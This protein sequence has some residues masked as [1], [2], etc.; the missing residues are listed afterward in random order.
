VYVDALGN[1][2]TYAEFLTRT[3]PG[4]SF[5]VTS[6]A[7]S[8]FKIVGAASVAAKVTRDACIEGWVFEEG[9]EGGWS[10]DLG[11]GYPS[12]PKTQAWIKNSIDP[13]FG[14]PALARFSWTTVKVALERDAHA[15]KWVD[16]GQEALVSAFQSA[17]GRDK[18]RCA[19]TKDL[20]IKSIGTL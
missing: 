2:T 11:S 12:D 20:G 15:V 6:K 3:F 9:D 1:T 5:T 10:R 7:D 17:V 13:V 16:E 19:V 8:K 14:L 18:D 4:I